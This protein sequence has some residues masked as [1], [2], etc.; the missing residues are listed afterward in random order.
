MIVS[1]SHCFFLLSLCYN[2]LERK[3]CFPLSYETVA[4][5][6]TRLLADATKRR[7]TKVLTDNAYSTRS[8]GEKQKKTNRIAIQEKKLQKFCENKNKHT[9]FRILK[10]ITEFRNF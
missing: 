1:L 4:K 7:V 10:N 3:S 9:C 6:T 5:L 2:L 8:K